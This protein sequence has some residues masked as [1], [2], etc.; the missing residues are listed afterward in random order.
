MKKLF[1]ILFILFS[2]EAECDSERYQVH[3]KKELGNG[4]CEFTMWAFSDCAVWEKRDEFKFEE[5]CT[6][7]ELSQIVNKDELAKYR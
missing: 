1:F 4:K 6:V 2:C 5:D 3:S 7:Y